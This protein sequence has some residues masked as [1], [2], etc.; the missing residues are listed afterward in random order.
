MKKA[1][2]SLGTIP[3]NRLLWN[4][5]WPATIGMIVNS[6]YNVV[7]TI[8]I[9]QGVGALAIAGL[10]IVF[11][12]QML[13]MAISLLI[14]VGAGAIVSRRLGEHREDLAELT[15]GNAIS[16]I[17]LISVSI[18]ILIVIFMN[19]ILLLCGVT[20]NILPYSKDYLSIILFG[21][22]FFALLVSINNL[23][24]AEGMAKTAMLTMVLTLSLNI[25]LD[26]IFIFG[27]NLGVKGAAG[28]TVISQIIGFFYVT[29]HFASR[30]SILHLR[31]DHF[32]I[33]PKMLLEIMVLGSSSLIRQ[34]TYIILI[35]LINNILKNLG[36]DFYIAV[37]G[38]IHRLLLLTMM[39]LF[40]VV[41]GFQPIAGYNYGANKLDR[42][43]KVVKSSLA[44]TLIFGTIVTAGMMLFTG[45]LFR[46]FTQEAEIIAIGV[47][48]LRIILFFFPLLGI[49]M[50]GATYYLAVGKART[51][52]LLT[53]TRQAFILI[54]LVL[55][56]PHFI[57]ILGVWLAFPI[58]DGITIG[59][60]GAILL[61]E[62]RRLLV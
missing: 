31:A 23:I 19:R 5:A 56:L 45:E 54:P 48:P 50:I 20:P 11:P 2:Q 16:A 24:R 25:I 1:H 7:D 51:A 46:L 47:W 38:I 29:W 8:Y 6:L 35:V 14:G 49:Q 42:V 40:G 10:S 43:K 36:G 52:I 55:I 17:V 32:R 12:I 60:T 34:G 26:P 22:P 44:V 39:P 57:G 53:L 9:G 33:K 15:A 13:I 21:S 18:V 30:R 58:S 37:Y 62:Y 61:K 41:Q 27:L 59:I 28:A 4:L 3:I